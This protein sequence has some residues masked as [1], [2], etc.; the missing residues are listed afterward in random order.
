MQL[1]T[2]PQLGVLSGC[3][4]GVLRVKGPGR[5]QAPLPSTSGGKT[6]CRACRRSQ[7]YEQ[8][9][10]VQWKRNLGGGDEALQHITVPRGERQRSAQFARM[11]T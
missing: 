4:L 9:A 7:L 1:W 8:W 5:A 3:V 11:D 2:N 10:R 6:L